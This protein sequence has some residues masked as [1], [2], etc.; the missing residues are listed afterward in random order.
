MNRYKKLPGHKNVRKD[1]KTGRYQAYKTIDGQQYSK[2][3][4]RLGEAKRWLLTFSPELE[5]RKKFPQSSAKSGKSIKK[6][7]L[8]IWSILPLKLRNKE[9]KSFTRR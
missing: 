5:A 2:D 7:V 8:W 4:A 1:L 6:F 9:F 3:F